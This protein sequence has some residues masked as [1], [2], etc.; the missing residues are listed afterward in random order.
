MKILVALILTFGMIAALI[1]VWKTH[2][3]ASGFVFGTTDASLSLLA[4]MI[5][6]V[7]WVKLVTKLCPCMAKACAEGGACCEKK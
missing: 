2:F 6:S 1:G 4:A 3:T 7:L 5:G